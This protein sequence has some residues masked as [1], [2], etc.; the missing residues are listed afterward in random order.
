[1]R[2]L[3][4]GGA[5]FIGSHLA[6][7]LLR[8]RHQV[9][10]LDDLSTGSADNIA[11][12]LAHPGFTFHRN[13]IFNRELLASLIDGQRYRLPPRRRRRRQAHHRVAGGDALKPTSP[14]PNWCSAWPPS[15]RVE[16]YSPPPPRSTA[17]PPSC[18]SA[19]MAILSS[20]LP[21]TAA[22]AMPAPRPSTSFSPSPGIASAACRSPS[23][24]CSTPWARARAAATAWC[25]PPSSARRCAAKP[26]TVYGSGE[27]SRC[28]TH[29]FDIVEGLAAIA[30]HDSH[31]RRNLQPRQHLG[32]HHQ[33]A[34][35]TGAGGHRLQQPHRSRPL[36]A[37]LRTRLR[38]YAAPPAQYRQGP[39]RLQLPA[40][41]QPPDDSR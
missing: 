24:A 10:V 26:I 37:G 20:E 19:K 31:H 33:P 30:R 27:Q 28:F 3:I 22:G 8:E 9:A 4:T 40:A 41:P 38:G 25:C 17:S 39:G 32:D 13:T 1:M 15:A 14:E 11:H 23:P 18:L 34:R 16:S 21:A 6:D 35:A 29:V 12:L 7:S 5:G 2:V 36:R